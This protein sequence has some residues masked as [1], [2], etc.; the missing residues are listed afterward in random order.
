M[1]FVVLGVILGLLFAIDCGSAAAQPT[2]YPGW[3]LVSGLEGYA[4]D[5][6]DDH[7]GVVA[8]W[9]HRTA[10]EAAWWE[11]YFAEGKGVPGVNN[12]VYLFPER[13]YWVYVAPPVPC[14]AE[15]CAQPLGGVTPLQEDLR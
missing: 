14:G 3:N 13:A 9:G 11:A 12:L 1:R 10:G 6:V 2:I 15:A 8:V 5:Y 7:P 4:Y